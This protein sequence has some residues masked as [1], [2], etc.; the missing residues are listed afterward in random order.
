M[1]GQV[2]SGVDMRV[3]TR[4]VNQLWP[5]STVPGGEAIA[6]LNNP[7]NLNVTLPYSDHMYYVKLE[8]IGD[9]DTNGSGY[10]QHY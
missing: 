7:V 5:D 10:I 2:I 4:Q 6:H 8:Q 9:W 3:L 1:H